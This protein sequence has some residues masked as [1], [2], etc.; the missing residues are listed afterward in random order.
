MIERIIKDYERLYDFIPKGIIDKKMR[1]EN[2]TKENNFVSRE[3][4]EVLVDKHKI[5]KL[6]TI[7]YRFDLYN[8]LTHVGCD[9]L[10][11]LC[12][13]EIVRTTELQQYRRHNGIWGNN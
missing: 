2:P 10:I 9:K 1:L 5:V 11:E 3:M 13:Q 7:G 8:P 6:D 4:Y 12:N